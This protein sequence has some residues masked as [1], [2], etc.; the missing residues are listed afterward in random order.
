[1]RRPASHVPFISTFAMGM[2]KQAAE[3][4]KSAFGRRFVFRLRIGSEGIARII[5]TARAIAEV[6]PV[7]I[8][9]TTF[10]LKARCS[11]N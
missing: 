11:A 6:G 8:E 1:M 9:P 3:A 5:S 2:A 7:G 10:G 4:I